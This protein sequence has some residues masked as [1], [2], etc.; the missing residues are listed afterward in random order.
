MV[1]TL[2]FDNRRAVLST[3]AIGDLEDTVDLNHECFSS[4][5]KHITSEKTPE[6]C[7]QGPLQRG[8]V[9]QTG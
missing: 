6:H 1:V 7:R 5:T 3:S 8:L 4:A 9:V 2:M